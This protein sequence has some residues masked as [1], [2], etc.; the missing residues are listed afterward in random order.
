ME[1]VWCHLQALH[2]A[3][4]VKILFISFR[5]RTNVHPYHVNGMKL[6]NKTTDK[7]FN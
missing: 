5:T 2:H 4:C 3:A 7:T 6:T 1:D